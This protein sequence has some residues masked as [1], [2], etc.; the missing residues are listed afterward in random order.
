MDRYEH[1]TLGV[2]LY[3]VSET[4]FYNSASVLRDV[5]KA[6][7]ED[8]TPLTT[9]EYLQLNADLKAAKVI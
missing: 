2:V 4:G 9:D 8:G 1:P 7:R 6:Q 3:T 5:D